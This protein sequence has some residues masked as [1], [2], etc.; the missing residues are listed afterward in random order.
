MYASGRREPRSTR[1]LPLARDVDIACDR[2]RH[3]IRA[4]IARTESVRVIATVYCGTTSPEHGRGRTAPSM[5]SY[6]LCKMATGM[7]TA[8]SSVMSYA[9]R[10]SG[11]VSRLGSR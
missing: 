4:Q 11:A 5:G 1:V 7:G 2:P 9:S 8:A 3:P 10:A 6:F